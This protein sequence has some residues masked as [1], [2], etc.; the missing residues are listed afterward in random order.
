MAALSSRR[1]C[2]ASASIRSRS[3]S[4][5]CLRSFSWRW[6]VDDSDEDRCVRLGGREVERYGWRMERR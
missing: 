5:K 1:T 3:A 6:V 2:L 4:V